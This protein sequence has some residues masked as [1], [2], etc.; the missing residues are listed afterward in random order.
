MMI[1]AGPE[2][3][4]TVIIQIFVGPVSAPAEELTKAGTE[5]RPTPIYAMNKDIPSKRLLNLTSLGS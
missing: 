1:A 3:R 5:T 4:T 2:I